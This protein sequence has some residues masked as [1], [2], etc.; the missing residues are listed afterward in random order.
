MEYLLKTDSNPRG[1]DL[2]RSIV[3]LAKSHSTDLPQNVNTSSRVLSG[4]ISALFANDS[5]FI[6]RQGIRVYLVL[7]V[8]HE[9]FVVKI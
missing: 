6:P 5:F 8:V 4:W 7:H 1:G 9:L 3:S 2:S